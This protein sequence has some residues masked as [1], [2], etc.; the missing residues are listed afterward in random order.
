MADIE[1]VRLTARD[2]TR[3]AFDSIN[4][5]LS[6]LQGTARSLTGV[7]AGL[8]A[9]VSIAGLV[10]L[11]KSSI[12]AADNLNKLSQ[13]V[14]TSVESLSKLQYAA[15]LSDISTEQLGDGLKKL[16]VNLQAAGRGSG[17]AVEAFKAL[18]FQQKELLSLSP[19][20]ALA[21]IAT[22]FAGIEDGAGKTALAVQIFGRSGSDLI[23][24]LNAGA[25]GLQ[26]YG[27]EAQRLGVVIGADAARAAE[28]FNDQLTRLSASSQALGI[29]LANAALP[30][31]AKFT[32]Q[33]LESKRIFGSFAS[34]L[35]NIGFAID[36]FKSLGENIKVYR[37]EV[38]RLDAAL[39]NLSA[40]GGAS[41]KLFGTLSGQR[42]TAGKRLEFLQ[43][44]QRQDA[45]ALISPSNSD[46]R[47]LA[48]AGSGST[49][50]RKAPGLPSK[51]GGKG[52]GNG[53]AERDRA[54]I[55]SVRETGRL[56]AAAA[57]DAA[58]IA[59]VYNKI[60]LEDQAKR[61]KAALDETTKSARDL[62]SILSQTT[63]GKLGE[64][65]REQGVLNDALVTGKINAEQFTE[66]FDALDAKRSDVLGRGADSF[67]KI[68]KDGIDAFKD[69]EFAIQGWGRQF[70]DTLA[71]AV[72]TG[73]LNFRSLAQSIV[74]DLLRMTIQAQI[75][76]PLF[77]A[78]SS[79]SFFSNGGVFGSGGLT[80]FASGGVVTRPTLFPFANGT[81]LM[82]E[83]GP[84]AI[85][86]LRRGPGGRL[87]VEASG[88]G[89]SAGAGNVTVVQHNIFSGGADPSTMA[90]WAQQVKS[91][92]LNTLQDQRRRGRF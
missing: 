74:S 69:L 4:K 41:S 1:I 82:G 51:G 90:A 37:G 50:K 27:D 85:M 88:S 40:T 61:D 5:S 60:D 47:D 81:G 25:D 66:A 18:G 63:S 71:D 26:R 49:A 13:R 31:L 33:L 14:G 89:D 43:L 24:L 53:A 73:K 19:D 20:Q 10:G 55:D 76:A 30:T 21:R 29:S 52:G 28:E 86:P 12:D 45:N 75:T 46:A 17:D 54:L 78:I 23:P 6:G 83:A 79:F 3:G 84:E 39:K 16:A 70:T 56:T 80:P 44:Q 9:G 77:K 32:E 15:K 65:E 48:L 7:L 67:S 91:D 68:A 22:A 8:G 42:D 87:G 72:V 62:Q 57:K 59:E 11:V 58:E 38:E 64:I 36:P 2:D 92:T 34:A 35:F